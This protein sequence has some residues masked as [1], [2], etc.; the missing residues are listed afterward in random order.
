MA[1]STQPSRFYDA[2]AGGE[3]Q[4]QLEPVGAEFKILRRFG[5]RDPHYQEPF[6]IPADPVA[7]RTDLASIPWF[8]AWL[9]P[10]LGTHPP[11]IL[12]HDALV[13]SKGEAGAHRPGGRQGR[14][15]PDPAGRD[16]QPGH[17]GHPSLADL[18]RGHPGHRRHH[19]QAQVVLAD[20]GDRHAAGDR[21]AGRGGHP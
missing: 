21:R 10:G 2:E 1:I 12:V 13:L 5:Y 8:F 20:H 7:F 6:I 17:T 9:V 14:C 16:G 19:P 18:D 3:L 15:R 11:A 4:L